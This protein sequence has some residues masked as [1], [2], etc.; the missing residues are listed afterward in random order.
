MTQTAGPV[1]G[2]I[3]PLGT[4]VITYTATDAAGNVST[5]S[6]NVNII[7][8]TAPI[9]VNC[10]SNIALN[11]GASCS[12]PASWSAPSVTDN[13]AG[14]S[15]AQTAGPASGSSFPIGI[16]T[17]VYTATDAGGNT[18]TCSFTVTVTDNLVPS[19]SCPADISVNN[20]VGTCGAVVTY[21]TPVGTDNCAGS[22]T[23]RTAGLASG[24]TFTVGTTTVT[25][26]VTDAGGLTASC[27]FT[28]TVIDAQAPVISCPANITVNNTVGI[29][30]AVV[31][32]TTPVGTDNCT[33]STTIRTA[34]LASGS[35]FPIGTT[36][37]THQVTD[38]AGLT[39]SCSFTVTVVD[40]Q[41][42]SIS[43]P[44]NI[45]VNSGAACTATA[46]WLT[47]GMTDNC[48][49]A[50]MT[51]TAGP[52]SGSIFPLGTTVITYT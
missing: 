40:A 36:T 45:T 48:P 50:I 38:A 11:S 31:T 35:T 27:S 9:V 41:A 13:C 22:T 49:G 25:H 46:S 19:I 37:V 18:S 1:S 21:T 6:F 29:C 42:P 28:I 44:A 43:C 14:A 4:T 10:P 26:Q 5:C 8:A 23:T 2:S 12:V 47:P 15:I 51:Q 33:G 34:G 16:T 20:T 3:F 32:Y 17:I 24:S 30:G 52:V 7:D 39:A